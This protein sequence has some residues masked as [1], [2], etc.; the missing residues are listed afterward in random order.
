MTGQYIVVTAQGTQ[1]V[2]GVTGDMEIN[3]LGGDD[4]VTIDNAFVNGTITIDTAGGNDTVTLGSQRIVSTRLALVVTLGDGNDVLSGRRLYI[5]G[6]QSFS[7]G[8]GNDQISFVGAA[9]PAEFILGTSS[10]GATTISGDNG[11]D[12]I[13]ATYSFIVGA[14]QFVGGAGDDSF[15]VRT[16]ACNG[17]VALFGGD[18]ADSLTVD[19][20]FFISTLWI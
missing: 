20:D 10:G 8:D 19:T 3:M 17:A 18:G 12:T 14:W 5:G 16:S 7:G 9:L 13:Q 1:S 15:S 4:Q 2:S 6:N 11:N